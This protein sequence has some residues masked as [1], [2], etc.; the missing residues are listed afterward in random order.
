M[1]IKSM[2][3][4]EDYSFDPELKVVNFKEKGINKCE[5]I[6]AIDNLF[7]LA[8]SA[9][10]HSLLQSL[11]AHVL[12]EK[13]VDYIVE[14]NEI[15]LVDMNTSRI[16]EGRSLSDGL[17]QAIESKE[18]LDN[19]EENKTYA[20]V[21]IQDYYRM[22]PHLAGMTGTAKT[23]EEEFRKVY[24]MDVIP[25]PP[26]KPNRRVDAQDHVFRTQEEKYAFLLKKRCRSIRKGTSRF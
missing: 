20:S 16:M 25:I 21:T 11:R 10:F 12:F 2:K 15:K 6:F 9:L 13:D 4:D 8:H 26:N 24:G 17:H 1:V 19:T 7:D 18:G 14:D 23:E 5:K 3:K 22:Y